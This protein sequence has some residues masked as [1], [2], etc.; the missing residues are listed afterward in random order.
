MAST[1][2]SFAAAAMSLV[3]DDCKHITED[4]CRANYEKAARIHWTTP[5]ASIIP[6]DF[7]L[8]DG[9]ATAHVTIEDALS[10]RTGMPDHIHHFGGNRSSS[11]SVKDEVRLLRHLPATAELRTK[12]MYNNLMYTAVSHAIETLIGENLGT[13]LHRRIWTPLHMAH[14]YWAPNDAHA[15][16]DVLAQGYAWNADRG[17]YVLEPPPDIIGGSGAGAMISSVVDYARWIRCMMTRGAPLSTQAHEALVQ[18][19]TIITNDPMN[20]F[21]LPH[22][23]ALGWTLDVYRG[24]RIVWHDGSVAGY[25]STMMY[26]PARQWGLVMAGNTTLTSN[27]VQVVLYMHLLDEILR[28]PPSERVD[29]SRLIRERR[30]LRREQQNNARQRLYPQLPVVQ[31][32][33]TLAVKEYAGLYVHPGYGKLELRVDAEGS[34]LA[35]DRT[36]CEVPMVVSL[37]HVSGEFWLANL[38]ERN[39]DPRDHERVRAEFRIGVDGRVREVG[40]DLE[41]EMDGKK[42]WF[43]RVM[44]VSSMEL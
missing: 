37:E 39:Q 25:G 14:T 1:T 44:S 38:Q 33:P 19:R 13:F 11:R 20:L 9:Y 2:K 36:A 30:I 31:L 23:Y 7:V 42:I 41:P 17:E 5:L 24:E 28:V 29:W 40:V 43:L 21:P 26:L 34:G 15:S 3:I 18:P 35:A 8:P 4:T 6:D 22:L 32:P 16:D 10:H 12:Y 27:I